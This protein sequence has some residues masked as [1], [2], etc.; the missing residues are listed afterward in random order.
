MLPRVT[1]WLG[2]RNSDAVAFLNALEWAV[3]LRLP[4]RVV[5]VPGLPENARVGA[6]DLPAENLE[7][8]LPVRLPDL[9]G[10]F[11][12]AKLPEFCRLNQVE[13]AIIDELDEH[14]DRGLCVVSAFLPEQI[15]ALLIEQAFDRQSTSLLCAS[16]WT[17]LKRPLL[18][19]CA[20]I[21]SDRTFL[22]R[23]SAVCGLM[24]AT[25]IVL[26][27]APTEADARR[28]HDMAK[29]IMSEEGLLAQFDYAAQW[30]L[31]AVIRLEANRRR[32]THVFLA[33]DFVNP[34]RCSLRDD[35]ELLVSGLSRSLSLVIFGT[36]SAEAIGASARSD[37]SRLANRR[38]F[39]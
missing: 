22:H 16:K 21:R 11:T 29:E 24:R 26:T 5:R 6:V 14:S 31:H 33:N 28:N 13:Y 36:D 8:W 27:I 35:A 3:R 18:V 7:S 4:L 17:M 2:E 15:R 37:S 12:F 9:A 23:A 25:P 10:G 32:C 30:D 38:E 39:G 20:M 19:N 34:R 1:V